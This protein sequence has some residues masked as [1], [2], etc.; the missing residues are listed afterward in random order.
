MAALLDELER[1][2]RVDPERDM[3]RGRTAR[4]VAAAAM[5]IAALTGVIFGGVTG[6]SISPVWIP[7]PGPCFALVM[8]T[9]IG[10]AARRS[11]AAKAPSTTARSPR[12][13]ARPALALAIH[14]A[15]AL[16]LGSPVVDTLVGDGVMVALA[17]T[18][19][20]FMIERWMLWGAVFALVYVG[21]A[22]VV[23]ADAGMGFGS[24]AI[25][26]YASAAAWRWTEPRRQWRT[27]PPRSASQSVGAQEKSG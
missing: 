15:L 23:P 5:A 22:V 3:H 27:L 2:L 9:G 19:A 17:M 13:S 20:G 16:H 4:R 14:R 6:L 12:W 24:L 18:L 1:P 25:L 11:L 7:R 21:F 8:M 10:V 26:V